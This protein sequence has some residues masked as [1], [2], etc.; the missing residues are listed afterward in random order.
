MRLVAISVLLLCALPAAAREPV[1][2]VSRSTC[3]LARRADRMLERACA[4]IAPTCGSLDARLAYRC[5]EHIWLCHEAWRSAELWHEA[6]EEAHDG[7]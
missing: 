1:R 4:L 6:C 5:D 2:D 7:R 3:T